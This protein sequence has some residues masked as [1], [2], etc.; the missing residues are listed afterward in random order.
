MRAM[1]VPFRGGMSRVERPGGGAQHD[2]DVCAERGDVLE[3]LS[4]PS[5]AAD[6]Y[7]GSFRADRREGNEVT[8]NAVAALVDGGHLAVVLGL[9]FGTDLVGVLIALGVLVFAGYSLYEFLRRRRKRED[10]EKLVARDPR[11]SRTVIPCGLRPDQLA[12]WCRAL[13][14]GDRNYGAEYGVEGPL[15]VDLGEGQPDELTVAAFRWW[16]EVESRNRNR[17]TGTV[18]R[19][20]SK[21]YLPAALVKLPLYLDRRVLI[22]PESALGRVGITRGGR[23]VESSEF[24]RR[25]RVESS[26]DQ[27]VLFLLDANFQQLLVERFEGR[28]I[29]LFGEL[30]LVGGSPS[31]RDDTLT[32]VIGELPAMRQ[33]AHRILRDIPAAFWRQV[34]LS[35]PSEPQ[36][37]VT[38]DPSFTR[39]PQQEQ[40]RG[41]PWNF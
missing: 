14:T 5:H 28:T 38:Q 33:D 22:R 34:G 40:Q 4:V 1:V 8:S 30:L 15:Q 12:W 2:V 9:V 27:L 32:G 18:S 19:S 41:F 3:Q 25:F 21:R 7:H 20:Y 6:A 29:E 39:R 31:H 35:Q 37:D 11:L 23:Q 17:K 24:N 10:L 36:P 16:W 13:E 26:D